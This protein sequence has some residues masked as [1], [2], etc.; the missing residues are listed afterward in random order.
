MNTELD[1]RL[2]IL[3]VLLGIA[4]QDFTV[5]ARVGARTTRSMVLPSASICWPRNY[6]TR[7]H[8]DVS[9]SSLIKSS[10]RPRLG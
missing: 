5:R 8:R 6:R 9:W 1:A 4:R 3:G 10:S 7:S 2:E